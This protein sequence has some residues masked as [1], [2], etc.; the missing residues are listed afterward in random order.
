MTPAVDTTA[1][2]AAM[3]ATDRAHRLLKEARDL[4]AAAKVSRDQD[5]WMVAGSPVQTLQGADDMCRG[6]G[7]LLGELAL[8]VGYATAG[9]DER[10]E[11]H[12]RRAG[13]GFIGLGG[14]DRMARPLPAPTTEALEL[15]HSLTLFEPDFRDR[16]HQVLTA[17][18]AT[19]PD[20][21]QFRNLPRPT[22][23]PDE[24]AD[25]RTA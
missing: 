16:I 11:H 13:Q 5:Q 18:E 19:Y 24:A 6:A 17:A 14:G 10:A 12:R 8:A 9:M 23:A 25:R 2:V 22:A 7:Q 1:L 20:P 21:A 15:L 3:T 4:L